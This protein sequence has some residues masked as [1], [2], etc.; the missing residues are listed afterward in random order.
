[1]PDLKRYPKQVKTQLTEGRAHHGFP[2]EI[3]IA[4]AIGF[5]YHVR[6]VAPHTNMV[7]GVLNIIIIILFLPS[8]K[9]LA[10]LSA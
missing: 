2:Y 4:S 3:G 7:K 9:V 1:M 8:V 10:E 5:F 6:I